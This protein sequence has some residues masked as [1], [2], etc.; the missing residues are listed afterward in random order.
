MRR[1]IRRGRRVQ[2]VGSDVHEL[3]HEPRHDTEPAPADVNRSA[4]VDLWEKLELDEGEG[5]DR[6]IDQEELESDELDVDARRHAAG[7]AGRLSSS[8][9]ATTPND[10]RWG[11]AQIL[12]FAAGVNNFEALSQQLLQVRFARP[13]IAAIQF[14]AEV[15]PP[16]DGSI[17]QLALYVTLGVGSSKTRIIRR[18]NAQPQLN[19]AIDLTI[20]DQ[21]L[22]TLLAEVAAV[23]TGGAHDMQIRCNLALAPTVR[24]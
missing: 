7:F 18:F 20:P 3:E 19:A 1:V 22:Q 21:P 11:D 5:G 6:D 12:T 10:I 16:G 17:T 2:V 9:G 13:L 8:A 24:T 4:G 23:G 14:H 15:L